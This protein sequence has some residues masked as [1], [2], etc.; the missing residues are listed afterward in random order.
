MEGVFGMGIDRIE[1]D[2]QT[3]PQVFYPWRRF[4]ARTLDFYLYN[5]IWLIFL[6]F[7][8][9]TNVLTRGNLGDLFDLIMTF[10]IMLL[11]EPL[12]LNKFATTPGKAIF[13]L[14]L[15]NRFGRNLSYGDA[16][17]RTWGVFRY[18][19]GFHLPIYNL[20][21]LYRSYTRCKENEEQPW[22]YSISYT[23]KDTKWY[24]NVLYVVSYGL[25][26]F[27]MFTLGSYQLLAP[28]RGDITVA[29]FV[30]NHNY[31]ARYFGVDFGGK[32]LD[33]DGKWKNR[34]DDTHHIYFGYNYLPDYD[35]TLENGYVKG[36]SFNV[37][38]SGDKSIVGSYDNQM[39]IV[40]LAFAGAQEEMHLFSRLPNRIVNHISENTFYSFSLEEGNIKLICETE[41]DGYVEA[42][43]S[44]I[45]LNGDAEDSYFNL[46]FSIF[47]KN[48]KEFPH[49]L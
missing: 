36:V 16:L 19:L 7:T 2:F 29:Q 23:I 31:Y 35:F 40:S 4:L 34:I 33:V 47:N 49:P 20:V 30:E 24:R 26:I 15:E 28:N 21:C 25:L 44:L 32:F 43:S 27:S 1:D 42:G 18:G 3:L 46:D 11:I 10:V 13:G 48:P 9:K 22:D 41:N 5:T 38:I 8:F 45:I 14:R 37:E 12:L 17:E 6:A 39:A